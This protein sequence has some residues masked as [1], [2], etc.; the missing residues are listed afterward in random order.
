MINLDSLLKS[1]DITLPTK[2]RLVKT[3]IFPVIMYGC[4]SWTI[5][6][7]ECWRMYAFELW[8]WRR[9][10]GVPWTARGSNQSIL[11][12]ISPEYSLEGLMLKLKLPIL[13]P[14]DVKNWLIGKDPDAGKDGRWEEKG[15]TEGAM[16]GWHNQLNGHDFE[17]SLGVGDGQGSLACCSPQ[18]HKELDTTEWLN[19]TELNKE[20]NWGAVV[21][22][23]LPQLLEVF[24]NGMI[25]LP[26]DEL[27][28]IRSV[29]A[30]R[31][32]LWHK[33]YAKP[34]AAVVLQPG[35]ASQSH[36]E[37]VKYTDHGTPVA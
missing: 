22:K 12:E 30:E 18:G 4:E 8:C 33:S 27:P 35:C 36:I 28:L 15:T 11:K 2:V 9:L 1:R 5:K 19:W 37:L 21:G 6:T 29:Q 13:R 14:P 20:T 26:G 24:I 31:K 17:Q 10:L 23:A 16:V 32:W 7:A 3:M 34:S 25:Y